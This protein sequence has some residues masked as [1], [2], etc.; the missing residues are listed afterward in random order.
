MPVVSTKLMED[1]PLL[2][3]KSRLEHEHVEQ[4]DIQWFP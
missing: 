4:M 2:E 3:V 1:F